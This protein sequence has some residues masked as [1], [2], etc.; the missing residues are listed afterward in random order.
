VEEALRSHKSKFRKMAAYCIDRLGPLANHKIADAEHHCRSLLLFAFCRYEPHGRPLSSFTDRFSVS[1][2]VLLTLHKWLDVSRSNQPDFVPE[3]RDLPRPV[4]AAG[5]RFHGNRAGRL[6][7]KKAKY[8]IAAKLLPEQHNSR[9]ICAVRLE[10]VLRQV[11][12]DCVNF[13][14]GRLHSSDDQ[15][16]HF[17]TAMP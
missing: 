1:R 2:I 14:H 9:P 7:G 8:L 11:Q 6:I 12:S 16:H 15:R 3:L 5:A 17:G 13:Q 4:V 10:N